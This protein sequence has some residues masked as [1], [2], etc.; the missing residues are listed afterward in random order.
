MDEKDFLK[1]KLV[2]DLILFNIFDIDEFVLKEVE[3]IKKGNALNV[4]DVSNA[5]RYSY[6]IFRIDENSCE[7]EEIS[8]SEYLNRKKI[9]D[10]NMIYSTL[11]YKDFEKNF[12]LNEIGMEHNQEWLYDY[13][14]NECFF[15]EVKNWIDKTEGD[16]SK[17]LRVRS[18]LQQLKRS[19]NALKNIETNWYE[20]QPINEIQK[21][22]IDIHLSFTGF[23]IESIINY[24]SSIFPKLFKKQI[25]SGKEKQKNKKSTNNP[26]PNIF[27]DNYYTNFKNYTEKNI[28]EPYADYSYLFQR[29]K[30]EK[31][32]YEIKHIEFAKWLLTNKFITEK[33]MKKIL[34]ER[35]FR[36]LNKAKSENRINNFNNLF[37]I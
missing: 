3:R 12:P 23:M 34:D 13:H 5:K 11:N 16:A 17:K 32:I 20:I 1:T 26:Y 30:F 25:K 9:G 24:Y 8:T 31:I 27:K 6:E 4:F 37:D 18:L 36:S 14:Y 35:G 33:T 28:I 21:V 22:V 2:K 7:E 19:N 15:P 10:D 29:M